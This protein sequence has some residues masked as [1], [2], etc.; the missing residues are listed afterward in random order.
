[1]VGRLERL[2]VD[3][4]GDLREVVPP[5][6]PDV[7]LS[8]DAVVA[9]DVVLDEAV[10][11]LAGLLDRS[12]QQARSRQGKGRGVGGRPQSRLEEVE[13]ERDRLLHD[14]QYRPV[15]H[16]LVGQSLR[17]PWLWKLR[18]WYR[19]TADSLHDRFRK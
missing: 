8:G 6:R 7:P 3:V 15:R 11:A 9:P 13:A 2:E 12:A 14:V 17:R 5:T 18:T 19:R 10:E 1:M 16:L 4:V